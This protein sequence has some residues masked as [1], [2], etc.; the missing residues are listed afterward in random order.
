M[1]C[2]EARKTIDRLDQERQSSSVSPDLQD[3]LKTCDLCRNYAALSGTLERVFETARVDDPGPVKPI[4]EQRAEVDARMKRSP[5][6]W[7]RTAGRESRRI[8]RP[9]YRRPAFRLSLATLA[10]ALAALTLV[11]FEYYQTVGYDLNLH[12][13]SRQLANGDE[14][15]C[16]LLTRLGLVEAGVDVKGCDTTCTL[17]ILDLKSEREANLVAGAIARLNEPGLTSN[18]VPIRARSTRSLLEQANEL[19][20]RG[21]S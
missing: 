13:V 18:I 17:A 3:H 19:I 20:R 11:P 15:I 2:H 9:F 12:G 14:Q 8:V 5:D 21:D 1:R 6:R 7:L 16:E 4:Y 10:V